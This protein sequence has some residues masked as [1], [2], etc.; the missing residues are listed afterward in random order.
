MNDFR[1]GGCACGQIHYEV[2]GP[3][4][5]SFHCYCRKC[6]R[7]T[8]G[9]HSS[10][11]AVANEDVILTGEIK[12]Y[13]Q[14]ADTGYISYSGFCPNC[15]SPILSKTERFP[16]RFYFHAATL[17]DPSLFRPEVVVFKEQAHSWDRANILLINADK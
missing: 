5:F 13:S 1:T 17:D 15:G 6:Q 11:F 16:D 10:A 14:P 4:E 9:G 8:G 7:S 2:N 12:Y 3:V